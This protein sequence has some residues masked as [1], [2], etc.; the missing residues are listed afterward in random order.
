MKKSIIALSM[1]ALAI[2]GM[3]FSAGTALALPKVGEK[4]PALVVK[5]LQDKTVDVS[6]LK[7]KVVVVDFWAT[8]CPPCRAE[9]PHLQ[10][11]YVKYG[12]KGVVVLGV[13][14]GEGKDKPAEFVKSNK[15]TYT[16]AY[17]N[18]EQNAQLS[19]TFGFDGIPTTIIIDKKG[20]VKYADSGFA[21]GMEQQFESI[22]KAAL[23]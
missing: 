7:G 5:S 10:D 14:V 8:W 18:Q 17:T 1:T 12:K 15:L 20:I 21:A 6:K 11:L 13:S 4:V 3:A 16:V 22:I 23:K 19:K 2:T 9:I